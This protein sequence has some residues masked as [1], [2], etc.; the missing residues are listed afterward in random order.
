MYSLALRVPVLRDKGLRFLEIIYSL[1]VRLSGVSCF[2]FG[3]AIY[4]ELDA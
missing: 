4:A 1:L 2:G 3:F